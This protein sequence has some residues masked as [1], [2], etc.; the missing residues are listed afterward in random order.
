MCNKHDGL[1]MRMLSC[2]VHIICYRVGLQLEPNDKGL[3]V[4]GV[5]EADFLT[6]TH[7]KQDFDD[8]PAYRLAPLLLL[9]C[10]PTL[11]WCL[12]LHIY[13]HGYAGKLYTCCLS[14]LFYSYDQAV[15]YCASNG[16]LLAC[17]LSTAVISQVC[18]MLVVNSLCPWTIPVLCRGLE[19]CCRLVSELHVRC[20]MSMCNQGGTLQRQ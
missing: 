3:G 7:N 13:V 6:P 19:D 15:R 5:V 8:T 12:S 4:L 9:L 20:I 11:H 1:C 17:T 14:F 16:R 10:R 18:N 2:H